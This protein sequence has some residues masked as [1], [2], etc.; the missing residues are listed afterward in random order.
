MAG[1][2]TSG[3]QIATW[4]SAPLGLKVTMEM[5]GAEIVRVWYKQPDGSDLKIF[6]SMYPLEQKSMVMRELTLNAEEFEQSL[7][8]LFASSHILIKLLGR[9]F[10]TKSFNPILSGGQLAYQWWCPF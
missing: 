10:Q 5:G 8:I 9:F 1:S 6:D 3:P 2:S 4:E 7:G